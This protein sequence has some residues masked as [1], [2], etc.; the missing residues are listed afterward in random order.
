M[1]AL[2]ALTGGMAHDFNNYLAVIIGN[3]DLRGLSVLT[4]GH[5]RPL[6]VDFRD[7]TGVGR[8]RARLHRGATQ[9]R[10]IVANDVES[11]VAA[12]KKFLALAPD[13]ASAPLV[14]QQL[15]VLAAQRKAS[16]SLVPSG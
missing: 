16:S 4:G 15:K 5:W 1:E 9:V 14:K 13:D 12:Y 2:G 7:W 11:A 3:L 6:A 10:Y 8:V